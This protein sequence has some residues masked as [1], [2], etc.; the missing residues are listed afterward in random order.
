MSLRGLSR[1]AAPFK[2]RDPVASQAWPIR[3][4]ARERDGLLA[5]DVAQP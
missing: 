3:H 2:R 5:G 1:S 4:D